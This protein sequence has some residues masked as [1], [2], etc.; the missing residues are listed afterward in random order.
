[1]HAHASWLCS[2]GSVKYYQGYWGCWV[3]TSSLQATLQRDSCG[4]EDGSASLTDLV[5]HPYTRLTES[6]TVNKAVT[7]Q[8]VTIRSRE[9]PLGDG[10]GTQL[11]LR[12][13]MSWQ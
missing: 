1:M 3:S 13:D 2:H 12:G 7:L 10:M 5:S 6:P 8:L 4:P 11:V 9:L